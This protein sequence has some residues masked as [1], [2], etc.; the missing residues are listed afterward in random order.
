MSPE[1]FDAFLRAEMEKNGQI[2]RKM[3]VKAD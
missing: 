3:N 1:A 2:I